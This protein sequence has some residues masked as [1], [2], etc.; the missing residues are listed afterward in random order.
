MTS[1]TVEGVRKLHLR[2]SSQS[3]SNSYVSEGVNTSPSLTRSNSDSILSS[4]RRPSISQ[5]LNSEGVSPGG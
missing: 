2:T 3:E 5:G 4:S 1:E